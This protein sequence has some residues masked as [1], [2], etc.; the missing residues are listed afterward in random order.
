MAKSLFLLDSMALAYRAYFALIANPLR[1]SKGENTSAIYGFVNAVLKIINDEKPDCIAAV[2]DTPEPTFRHLAYKEYKATR[3]RMPEEMSGQLPLLKEVTAALG[4]PVIEL[5]GYEADDIIG[6]LARQAEKDGADVFLVSGDK[7]FMQLISK[8]VRMYNPI[9][10]G[11]TAE[12]I[13]EQEVSEKFGVAPRQVTDILGLMGDTADNIPGVKGI[14]AKTAAKLIK[15]FDSIDGLYKNLDKVKGKLF[16]NLREHKA[17]ALL[18]RKLATIQLDVPI[19]VSWQS[20]ASTPYQTPKAVALFQ[21]L[22]F[23]SLVKRFQKEDAGLAGQLP[24][25]SFLRTPITNYTIVS[26]LADLSEPLKQWTKAK[27]LAIRVDVDPANPMSSQVKGISI[28]HQSET[29][30][31]VDLTVE[32]LQSALKPLLENDTIKKSGPYLKADRIGLKRLGIKLAGADFDTL[33]AGHLLN[34]ERN[35]KLDVIAKEVLSVEGS[36][37]PPDS[38]E[39]ELTTEADITLRLQEPLSEM[40][41]KDDLLKPFVDIEMALLPVLAEM[42]Y[43]G[44]WINP[45]ILEEMSNDFAKEITKQ[46]KIVFKEAGLEF[47]LNSPQQLGEVLFDKL[48][49]HKIAG[50]EKPKRTGK[51]KQYAT[52][53]RILELYGSLPVI[54][55][56][57]SYRQLTKLKSTYIDGLPPLI[58]PA[59]SRIHSTFS[60]TVAATGRLSSSNPNFQNI[61]IRT[62]MGREIRRAFTAQEP[63]WVLLSADYSQIELRVLAHLSN[64]ANLKQAFENDE[65]IHASTAARVF[66]LD[67]NEVPRELRR[68]AK[69]INFG[70]VYGIS[71]FGLASRIGMTQSE[72]RDFIR[73]YFEKYPGIKASLDH[74]LEQGRSTGYVTTLFGRRRYLPDLQSKNY[75][76]RQNAERAAINT[77]I[78][79]TAAEIIKMAMIRIHREM[80]KKRMKSKMILQVHDELVFETAKD[81]VQSLSELVKKEMEQAVRLSIPLKVDLGVGDNWL[82]TK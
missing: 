52:D 60:Q 69:D 24:S 25:P 71:P 17:E 44:V 19:K 37:L 65:D 26:T 10:K 1:N 48:Q 39:S 74:T 68:K 56:I 41:S 21:Q 53:V 51:T 7:D 36:E 34:S 12:V 22:E 42:E 29:G 45:D 43:T 49:I 82:E 13:G 47:N 64:D 58:N 50:I 32:S 30:C 5:P 54:S 76:V 67:I 2:F 20:L 61:P 31:Y 80:D 72:A 62:D 40:L 55:A 75:A 70:I 8:R 59:T 4:I 46:E 11:G 33:I 57:L 66:N 35:V 38:P 81:E 3:E 18:S 63:G 27:R 14:G 77:P 23:S 28:S 16:E 78:Q 9:K 79:G 15:E 6:T 73:N